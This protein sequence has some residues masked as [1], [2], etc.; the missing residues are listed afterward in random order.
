MCDKITK[1][2]SREG[3]IILLG[4]FHSWLACRKGKPLQL[5]LSPGDAP[6]APPVSLQVPTGC[7]PRQEDLAICGTPSS[8]APE[9]PQRN[10][11]GFLLQAAFPFLN[12][13]AIKKKKNLYSGMGK[14]SNNQNQGEYGSCQ[15]V[16]GQKLWIHL[17]LNLKGEI[18][19]P[20]RKRNLKYSEVKASI[21][22]TRSLSLDSFWF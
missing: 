21:L 11:L 18:F 1:G 15:P 9:D 7:S 8:G 12:S 5:L 6:F 20:N 16:A 19:M 3:F 14:N 13:L 4:P 10:S 2:C 17:P 22:C